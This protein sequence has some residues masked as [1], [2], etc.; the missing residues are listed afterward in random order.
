MVMIMG[1]CTCHMVRRRAA[2]TVPGMCGVVEDGIIPG[3]FGYEAG[4]SGVGD[5]FAWFVDNCVPPEYHE[6]AEHEGI[7]IHQLLEAEAAEQKPGECGL[8]ALDWWNGNR[9]TWST[10]N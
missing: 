2:K 5:I 4:Q 10:S 8:L 6:A 1:T 7:G 9:S 3:F